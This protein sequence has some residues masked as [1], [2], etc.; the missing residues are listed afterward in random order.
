MLIKV[1]FHFFMYVFL[2]FI[3]IN[4]IHMF[5]EYKVKNKLYTVLMVTIVAAIY[6]TIVNKNS[7]I[8]HFP[9]MLKLLITIYFPISR[10]VLYVLVFR[11]ISIKLVYIFLIVLSTNQIYANLIKTIILDENILNGIA[12]LIEF[13]VLL[14]FMVYIKKRHKEEMYKRI[15][16]SLPRKLYVLILVMLLIA[17]VFVMAALRDDTD[18]IMQYFLIP[19]MIGLVIST[20]AIIKIGISE[21][22][23]KANVD[24]LSKQ[25]ES[26]I[27]YY[28]KINKIYGEFRSFRHDYKNHVLC[29][30]GLIAADKKEEAL[31]YMN[32]MQDMSSVGKNKYHT[33]NVIID[34]LLDDK[35]EKAEKV[36]TK[37]EFNGI[38]PTSGISNADLCVIMANAIDNAIEACSKDESEKEKTIKADADFKQGYFFFKASNPMFEEVKFK[39]KN[40]VATSKS[41]KE[42][43]GFGV[44]N[45]VRTA[46]KYDGTAEISTDNNEF[47]IDVQL[48]LKQA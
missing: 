27:G 40:K 39:G 42:H 47:T 29:L 35:S 33:G 14:A 11:K 34:A 19:S 12:Y 32:T 21:T 18:G 9:V 8:N 45:I 46:E 5:S 43:H 4:Y 16:A 37:L 38:V 36:N 15:I 28:E 26:Q 23:K 13:I 24:I 41:D 20:I 48:L 10:L 31:E 1:L 30:R 2:E 25:V 44:A 3:V 7:E 17:S 22:E 6:C